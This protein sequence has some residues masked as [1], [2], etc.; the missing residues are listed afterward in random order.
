M[1]CLGQFQTSQMVP[2]NWFFQ[3]GA[4]SNFDPEDPDQGE[5]T[6]RD[7]TLTLQPTDQVTQEV[8]DVAQIFWRL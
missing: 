7:V 8:D 6:A 4:R 5:F 3:S 1:E 2:L